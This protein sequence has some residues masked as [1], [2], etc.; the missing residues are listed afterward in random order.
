MIKVTIHMKQHKLSHNEI[1]GTQTDAIQLQNKTQQSKNK[2]H[3]TY[4]VNV[5][6]KICEHIY[7]V[8]IMIQDI[9]ANL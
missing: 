2:T 8:I 7:I 1:F 5:K 9:I 4:C 6:S 3:L